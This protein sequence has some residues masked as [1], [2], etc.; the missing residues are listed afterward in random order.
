MIQQKAFFVRFTPLV[1]ATLF[2]AVLC[3]AAFLI[4]AYGFGRQAGMEEEQGYV[5]LV[6]RL[7]IQKNALEIAVSK[8]RRRA[9]KAE[10]TANIDRLAAEEVRQSLLTYRREVSDLQADVEFYRRLMA[11]EEVN[12]GLDL[13]SFKLSFDRVSKLYRYSALVTNST[14]QNPVVKGTLGLQLRGTELLAS[15]ESEGAAVAK[16]LDIEDSPEFNGRLPAQLRFRFFQKVEGAFK[17]PEGLTPDSILVTIN[18]NAKQ[19]KH[20]ERQFQWSSLLSQTDA[21]KDAQ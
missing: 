19:A 7:E 16:L 8:Q 18:S 21:D 11:P 12:K 2:L 15:A 14:S 5:Q 3:F 1:K 6:E 20:L 4:L 13:Y 9:V 10:T 17:L